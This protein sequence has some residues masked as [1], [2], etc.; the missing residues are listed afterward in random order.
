MNLLHSETI[1]NWLIKRAYLTPDRTAITF[2]DKSLTFI[3]LYEEA[4]KLARKLSSFP[5]KQGDRVALLMNN[6]L[7]TVLV[8]HALQLI[9]SVAIPLNIRLHGKE[10]QFQLKDSEASVLLT[11]EVL[12]EKA[13]SADC[14]IPILTIEEI[15]NFHEA[16]FVEAQEFSLSEVCTMMYTSGT[17]GFPKGVMQTYG[18]HWWSAIGSMLNLGLEE[19][20]AWVAVVPLFHISGFSILVRSVIYGIPIILFEHFDEKEVNKVLIEGKATI[21]S[22]VTVMLRRLVED[23]GARNYHD[24]FRCALLGGGPVPLSL[25]EYCKE[26]RIPVFQSYGL[27]E[28]SSQIV[29]LSPE[30]SLVKLGSAGKPL[31][32]S[33][34]KIVKDG[35]ITPPYEVGEIAVKGPNVTKGY[36]RRDEANKASFSEDGWFYTGDLGYLDEEGF[37]Y[38]LDRRSDLIISGGENIYPAEVENI[39]QS[40]P[41][42]VEAAVIGI[43]DQ[44]WGQVPC[45]FYVSKN[46]TDL[47]IEQLVQF[48]QQHLAKYKIPKKWIR[49]DQLPKNASN[50]IMR[51][52]LREWVKNYL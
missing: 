5:I 52:I 17:T 12:K 29:T 4:K 28:T 3:E 42:V 36:Y 47:P 15:R 18:N 26:K 24:S 38:V 35:R 14:D 45:A 46:Q 40:H 32:P 7:D 33:K 48:C 11:R 1:P 10:L 49:V 22:V 19:R 43:E 37:L 30:D 2:E 6:H 44:V 39:L 9:G 50:K 41:D 16:D 21:I 27:T 20:D 23:L 13:E 51:R 34:I 31:F 25:L 8:Y